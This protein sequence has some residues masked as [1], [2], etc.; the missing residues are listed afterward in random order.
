MSLRERLK[1]KRVAEEQ[2][3]VDGERFL[4]IG[5]SRLARHDIYSRIHAAAQKEGGKLDNYEVEGRLLSVA[6]RDAETGEPIFADDEWKEWDS[7]PATITGPL[8]AA[9]MR[10]N[11]FDNED[12]GREVKNS[13]AT[14][15]SA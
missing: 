10:A 11:G 9:V 4:V 13:E 2:V 8:V 7:V 6:V 1:A 5:M 15:G 3:E 12:V 14:A